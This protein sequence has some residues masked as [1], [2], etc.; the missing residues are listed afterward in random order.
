MEN[1]FIETINRVEKKYNV[2]INTLQQINYC[3]PYRKIGSKY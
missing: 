1:K 2:G 3:K